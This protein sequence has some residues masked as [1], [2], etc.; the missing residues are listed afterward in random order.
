M[1]PLFGYN[2]TTNEP[3]YAHRFITKTLP[4]G[5]E[6]EYDE[7]VR[8]SYNIN[9]KLENKIKKY[10]KYIIMFGGILVVIC[11][12]FAF[13]DGFKK[14]WEERSYLLILGSIALVV[15][16]VATIVS[17]F[18][19]PKQEILEDLEWNK[20]ELEN[21]YKKRD[22]YFDVPNQKYEIDILCPQYSMKKGQVKLEVP[23]GL[24]NNIPS[25]MYKDEEKLYITDNISLY[26][27][28]FEAFKTII[29]TKEKRN[30]MNWTQK[31]EYGNDIKIKYNNQISKSGS[32]YTS[33]TCMKIVFEFEEE[34]YYFEVLPYDYEDADEIFK[35][36]S[37]N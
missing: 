13:Q 34:E 37:E 28:P 15:G 8:A 29:S 25:I 23:F 2:K 4:K 19:K 20:K 22:E 9:R 24:Y 17:R 36:T 1:K 16:I 33:S 32:G 10:S 3:G 30:F 7:I 31:E 5:L 21:W 27:I 18:I 6:N 12:L 35:R 11:L 26:E 14:M